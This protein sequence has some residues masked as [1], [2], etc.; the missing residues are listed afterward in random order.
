MVLQ[1]YIKV[2]KLG[3]MGVDIL[4]SQS[5]HLHVEMPLSLQSA[6]RLLVTND[7]QIWVL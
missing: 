4:L 1:S 5:D 3:P 7:A 6:R 2:H